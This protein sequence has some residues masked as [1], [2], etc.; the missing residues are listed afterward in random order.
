MLELC[1]GSAVGHLPVFPWEDLNSCS[2]QRALGLQARVSKATGP[3]GP[4]NAVR[5]AKV[6]LATELIEVV[7]Y[8]RT[9]KLAH[10]GDRA[11]GLSQGL[12]RCSASS[13]I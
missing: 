13:L 12:R 4:Y 3:S 11:G 8:R 7:I 2:P 6:Q 5:S 1:P 10:S 9:G